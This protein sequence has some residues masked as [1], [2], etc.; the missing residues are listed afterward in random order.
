LL[1]TAAAAF[2]AATSPGLSGFKP[3]VVSAAHFAASRRGQVTFAV[4]TDDRLWGR[5]MDR[6]APSAS[7]LKALLLVTHLR[8]AR[9]RP[10]TRRDRELLEPMIRRS[11]NDPASALVVKYGAKRIESVARLAGMT[12][13]HLRSPWGNS[14]VTARDLTRFALRMESLMPARHRA[15]GMRL[16]RTITP[17]QRWGIAREIPAGWTLY[18][19][20]G[21]G[22]GTGRVDHQ[23]ALLQRGNDRIAVAILTTA[24]GDHEYGKRTLQG[25]A[26]R[27][28]HRL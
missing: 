6:V 20:S 19:K 8:A 1:A 23:V 9:N 2:L 22:S 13:F 15:Y 7:T 12:Q 25:V 3:D 18:F 17:S 14:T 28:L 21:W 27:L 11:A 16:L 26:K 10:L 5:G 24:Q 4:R